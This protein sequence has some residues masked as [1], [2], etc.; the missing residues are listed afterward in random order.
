MTATTEGTEIKTE[1]TESATVPAAGKLRFKFKPLKFKKISTTLARNFS[2]SLLL[3]S[4]LVVASYF[5]GS[6]RT[7][8]RLLSEQV[9]NLSASSTQSKVA[10]AQAVGA[11]PAGN[12]PEAGERDHTRGNVQ[13]KVKLIEY[14]DLE[15]P[16]CKSFHPTLQQI[17]KDYG[18]KVAWVYRHYPLS[19]HANAQKEAEA[20]E[21]VAE[22]GG[23]DKFWQFVDKIFERTTSNGTGFALSNLGPLA[24]EVGVNQGAFQTCLDS[25]KYAQLVKDQMEGG[26]KAG[27][28][29]TPGTFIVSK[30]G[31]SKLIQGALPLLQ[32]KQA[33]DAALKN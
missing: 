11:V 26:S 32:V 30:D 23:N 22:L 18:S 9:A 2:L 19:F 17:L 20:T 28:K 21:C 12:V 4:M 29:G 1:N 31:S 27:V 6:M 14:S 13:A 10:G 3:M 16:F 5:I 7:E 33:V 15:C 25:G 24:A 8:N